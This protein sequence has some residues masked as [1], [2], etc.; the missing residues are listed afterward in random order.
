MVI[1]AVIYPPSGEAPGPRRPGPRRNGKNF[2][3]LQEAQVV[4]ADWRRHYNHRRPHSSL[5]YRPSAPAAVLPA[6]AAWPAA[7]QAVT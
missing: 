6:P 3:T 2:Y 5:G 7:A 4:I 1:R